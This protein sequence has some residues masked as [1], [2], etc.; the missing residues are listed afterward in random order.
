MKDTHKWSKSKKLFIVVDCILCLAIIVSAMLIVID[1]SRIKNGVI[2]TGKKEETSSTEAADKGTSSVRFMCVGDNLIHRSI[3]KQANERANGSGYD[4]GYAYEQIEEIIALSDLAYINQETIIDPESE[5]STYP[6]FNSPPELL[7]HM[8]KI[9]FDVFNQANNHCMDKFESGALNDIKLFKSKQNILLTGLYENRED[10]MTPHTTTVNGITFSFVGFTEYLN[11]L[12][13][14]DD[15]ELGLIYLDDQRTSQEEIYANMKQMIDNAKQASD[16]VCVAM[17]WA[18]EDITKPDESQEEI[19]TKLMEYG[20][21][22]IIGAGPHVLQPIEYRQNGD[23][24]QAAIIWS[25]GNFISCQAKIDELLGG[26][27]D[28]TVTKDNNS[29]K[30]S[31]ESVKFIPT[32]TMYNSGYTN[33]RIVPYNNFTDELAAQHG[34]DSGTVSK[35]YITS[36]YNEMYGDKLEMSWKSAQ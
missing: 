6:L 31:V 10:M 29:G 25:L 24:E 34:L 27:A 5:P 12:V 33:V 21:D 26:I 30:A 2:Y 36:F 7:D 32:V 28:I 18:T 11:G 13:V 1:R 15:S 14:P 19:M 4:F 8:I 35:E 16:V 9:G 22:I 23:G 17:H 20:A 3:Y